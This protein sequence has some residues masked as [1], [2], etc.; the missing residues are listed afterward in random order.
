M[1]EITKA[2]INRADRLANMMQHQESKELVHLLR[3]LGLEP[4]DTAPKKNSKQHNHIG[5]WKLADQ[6]KQQGVESAAYERDPAMADV[7]PMWAQNPRIEAVTQKKRIVYLGESAARGFLYD[8]MYTPAQV[9]QSILQSRFGEEEVEVVD[10]ARTNADLTTISELAEAAV[11]LNPDALVIF[12]GNNWGVGANQDAP[13]LATLADGLREQGVSGFRRQ[14]ET[15][16]EA[17]IKALVD[18]VDDLYGKNDI[19]VSWVIPEFCLQDWRDPPSNAPWLVTGRNQ[20][21]QELYAQ[22][23]AAIHEAKFDRAQEL[24]NQMLVLDE[25]NCSVTHYLLAEVYEQQGETQKRRVHLQAACDAACWDF[26][27]SNSPRMLSVSSNTLKAEVSLNKQHVIDLPEVFS[28]YLNADSNAC[29]NKLPGRELFLDYCHLSS[30]GIKVAMA[31]IASHHIKLW[32]G[33]TFEL[34]PLM[35][36]STDISLQT[37]SEGHFL[38]AIHNA[39][40]GQS[41]ELVEYFCEQALEKD[42]AIAE[43]MQ[44]FMEVQTRSDLPLWMHKAS[45][46]LMEQVSPNLQRYLFNMEFKCF[47]KVLFDAMTSALE[48]RGIK[49]GQRLLETRLSNL[50]VNEQATDL[51]NPFFHSTAISNA[52]TGKGNEGGTPAY[53]QAYDLQNHFSFV[54]RNDRDLLLTATLRLGVQLASELPVKLLCN[55]AII[56]EIQAGKRWKTQTITMAAELLNEGVNQLTL[57]WKSELPQSED[58]LKLAANALELR[59]VPKLFPVFGNLFQL[60]VRQ[61][62]VA[63]KE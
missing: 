63:S 54:A 33:E 57:S 8:P 39:H 11:A 43:V 9:L 41:A 58:R 6:D 52:Q 12:A 24:A 48:K 62:D 46:Q 25:E 35:G 51:L 42:Q 18:K 28:Q 2:H 27:R 15:C 36:K 1:K 17:D 21:W 3:Q 55:G 20:Q 44:L 38:A 19:P 61:A 59:Q 14:I 45:E 29:E 26:M 10:L 60:S 30:E 40:W 22:A 50:Q 53:F 47:D 32:A 5:I 34:Q 16:L 4:G 23:T 56:A 13:L 49:A 37:E 31:A 7:W